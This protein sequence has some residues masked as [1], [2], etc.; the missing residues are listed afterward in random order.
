MAQEKSQQNASRSE[1]G[2]SQ[3]PSQGQQSSGQGQSRG[4]ARREEFMPAA[5][6]SEN[7]FSLMRRFSEDMDRFF[8][9]FFSGS[10]TGRG[11]LASPSGRGMGLQRGQWMPPIE[12]SERDNKIVVCAELPGLSKDDINVEVTDDMLTIS[13]ERRE[14]REENKEGYRHSERHYGRFSRSIGLPEGAKPED[15]HASFQNGVLE[16][17]IPTPEREQRSR[18]IEIQ[19]SSRESQSKTA[20]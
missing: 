11:S 2:Q 6:W 12:V 14:E 15:M 8:G 19:D 1:K 13:G 4:M 3:T 16:I 9:D 5:F 17:T 20:H 7:P 10:G 18:R